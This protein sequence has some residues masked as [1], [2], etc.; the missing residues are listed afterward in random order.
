LFSSSCFHHQSTAAL[1]INENRPQYWVG[2]V[3]IRSPDV[4]FPSLGR[5]FCVISI[6]KVGKKGKKHFFYNHMGLKLY[7]SLD[8]NHRE[9]LEGAFVVSWYLH[10]AINITGSKHMIYD[11]FCLGHLCASLQPSQ[12][13][14][15]CMSGSV[16]LKR[17]IKPLIWCSPPRPIC[18]IIFN[19][20][21]EVSLHSRGRKLTELED[22]Q[23]PIAPPEYTI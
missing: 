2:F 1:L 6:S 18:A 20:L 4:L 10:R 22:Q 13:G 21:P 7:P 12:P 14:L 3:H 5:E 9:I 11:T 16:Y 19:R 23:T 17:A 8:T 15:Y